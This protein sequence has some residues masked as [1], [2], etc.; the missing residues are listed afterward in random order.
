MLQEKAEDSGG[1]KRK[2]FFGNI[3]IRFGYKAQMSKKD[4]QKRM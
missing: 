4:V 1:K 2:W 3:L